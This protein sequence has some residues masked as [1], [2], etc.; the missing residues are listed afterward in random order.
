MVDVDF[1]IAKMKWYTNSIGARVVGVKLFDAQGV[2]R[3]SVGS[4]QNAVEYVET[5]GPD[6]RAIGLWTE[7]SKKK[8]IRQIGLVVLRQENHERDLVTNL[9]RKSLTELNKL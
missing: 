1:E 2:E 7:E 3:A 9:I 4:S 5:V 6:E 8:L